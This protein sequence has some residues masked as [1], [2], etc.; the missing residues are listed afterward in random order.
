MNSVTIFE[1]ISH[2]S[3]YL[4]AVL[5]PLWFLPITQ[6]S[7]GYQKQAL[8][9]VLVFLGFIA[10]LAKMVYQG[11]LR[12]RISW[13]HAPVLALLGAFGISTA[14]SLWQYGSFWGWPLD[15]ADNL[16]T[17]L[18]FTLLYFL[19]SQSIRDAK[20]L[21]SVFAGFVLSGTIAV[22]FTLLQMTEVFLIPFGFA[23]SATF[24]T[25]ASANGVALIAAILLPLALGLA[26]TGQ[27]VWKGILWSSAILLFLS[28]VLLNFFAAWIAAIVG[29]VV[30]LAFD[31]LQRPKAS[32][33]G[34]LSLPMVFVLIALFFLIVPD[35]SLPGAPAKQA[36]VLPS[37][38]GE[39]GMVQSIIAENPLAAVIGTGPGTFVYDYSKFRGPDSNQSIFWS[40]RFASGRAEVLDWLITKGTLG[41]LS[42]LVL[43]A[44]GLVFLVQAAMK[45]VSAVTG[46]KR[47]RVSSREDDNG[48]TVQD[49]REEEE[50]D[51]GMQP[52]LVV[53][54]L[55]ALCAFGTGLFLYPANFALWFL[56]WMIAGGIAFVASKE[57]RISLSSGPSFVALAS[58]A[59]LMVF[60]ILGVGLVFIGGQKYAAE[61][62][63]YD[64]L[65][66]SSRGDA[67]EAVTKVQNA[68]RL[69]SSVDIYWRDLAQLYLG[70]A[71]QTASDQSLA[72]EVRQ[73]QTG[74]AVNRAIESANQ[75]IAVAPNNVANWNVRGF[76]YRSLIG[77]PEADR[78][79]IQ[80]YEQ[81]RE[82][83]PASPFVWTE[84][85]RVK[86]LQAQVLAS[87]SAEQQR[88][89]ELLS[90]AI[91][92]LTRAT[93][94]KS[95]YAPAHYLL[96]VA[97]DQQGNAAQAIAQLEAT[98]AAAPQDAGL[99]FQLGVI[100]YRQ[101]ELGKARDEFE[102]AKVA[103]PRYSNA[104]Y[105]LGLVYDRLGRRQEAIG[106][107]SAV[108]GLNPDNQEVKTILANLAAGRSALDGI[109]QP[110]T[111]PIDD[112]PAEIN[113][114]GTAEGGNLEQEP[115]EQQEINQEEIAPEEQ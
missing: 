3:L 32:R 12:F 51:E 87:Q 50:Q 36:E 19:I 4:I 63:Y 86:I 38:Q 9:V 114:E 41:L 69:N 2:T 68:A 64:A 37:Y 70:Q 14:F 21:F 99:A 27:R 90:G 8:L 98:K 79:A 42:L 108:A 93:E 110:S 5:I 57:V 107:F 66:A 104:R 7:L 102:R 52:A 65:Q 85:G 18:A 43:L 83:E 91:D 25:L 71:N 88:Q 103:N 16:L 112:N 26:S 60:L 78:F 53:S 6:N 73:Q 61:L 72:A 35:F 80:S 113:P 13:L 74:A 39:L 84:L 23:Q 45:P 76:V 89:Q 55:G 15:V 54:L 48:I 75:A 106:E 47:V 111:P 82:L 33:A 11:E 101:N 96:A 28:M 49:V 105:M 100:Y 40:T 30:L 10:W 95:D 34:R 109:G 20:Q 22:L 44:L 115:I 1:K 59:G 77:V 92:D 24:N 56:F 81:A 97:Y 67:Q 94:L 17:F 46:S 29:L 31:M 62:Q 58:S